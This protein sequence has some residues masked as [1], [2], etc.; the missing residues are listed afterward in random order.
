MI[1]IDI[2]ELQLRLKKEEGK[3]FV[4]DPVR[5]KW[6]VLTPE[7][8][9]R[10]YLLQYFIK[11]L[12]Y[13]TSL[14][15]VEKKIQCGNMDKRFDIVVYNRRHQPWLLTECKAPDVPVNETTLQQL[16]NYQ[17][18]LQCRYWIV[19]NGPATFCAD[20]RNVNDIKWLQDLPA[21]DS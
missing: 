5:K 13:P 1:D 2:S 15:A 8:H 12:Q 10:Q 14:I 6:L 16:L 18:N 7:E 20:A 3:T 4:F 21:Y 17:R 11:K 9:V 19:S